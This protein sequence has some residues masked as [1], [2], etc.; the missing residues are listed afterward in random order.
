MLLHR[1]VL[2]RG[3][4]PAIISKFFG[5]GGNGLQ[6]A[7]NYCVKDNH[8]E[9]RPEKIQE[10]VD[11][12][13]SGDFHQL[14]DRTEK[15]LNKFSHSPILLNLHGAALFELG[16]EL[17]AIEVYKSAITSS[18]TYA[19]AYHNLAIAQLSL[20]FFD[21]A[22]KNCDMAI[23]L[24][25]DFADALNTKA[26]VKFAQKNKGYARRLLEKAIKLG[27]NESS[28]SN[29]LGLICLHEKQWRDAV[30]HFQR[31]EE[32]EPQNAD[33]ITNHGVALL[34]MGKLGEANCLFEKVIKNDPTSHSAQYNK[35]NM[36]AMLGESKLAEAAYRAAID[37]LAH[38][39]DRKKFMLGQPTIIDYLR[40]LT[41]ATT[42]QDDDQYVKLM[43]SLLGDDTRTIPEKIQLNFALGKAYEDIKNYEKSF[44]FYSDGNKFLANGT[45]EKLMSEIEQFE[46]IKT[47]FS[48]FMPAKTGRKREKLFD[49]ISPVFIVGMPRSGTTLVEQILASHSE[50]EPLG[51]LTNFHSALA[52]SKC[53]ERAICA[54][55]FYNIG[56]HYLDSIR[57]KKSEKRYFTDKMPFNFLWIGFILMAIPNAKIIHISRDPMAVCWSNFKTYFSNNNATY[58]TCLNAIGTY[59]KSYEELMVFWEDL[60]PDKMYHQSYENLTQDTEDNI[61]KILAYLELEWEVSCL[62]FHRNGRTVQT[63]SDFQVKKPI[64]NGSSEAWLC[65]RPY[66]KE[67]EQ[68]LAEAGLLKR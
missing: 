36:H 34:A 55:D 32:L 22:N 41:R 61:R 54:E 26:M 6:I 8:L 58:H 18:P 17:Q 13:Q 23:S 5:R 21:E 66:L 7:A 52:H 37:I 42:F 53:V 47:Q 65:Y 29:N 51:E 48:N 49:T 67:L 15:L 43:I 56:A 10:L 27:G 20:E 59:Y 25:H 28:Y 12:Y 4:R 45:S 62:N 1:L 44:K 60:F 63:A 30:Y 11:I 31:A 2:E 14:L 50:V 38:R 64:Y 68:T 40:S 39:P 24:K 19:Q 9:P 35:G 46:N 16:N 57:Y 33:A 3:G